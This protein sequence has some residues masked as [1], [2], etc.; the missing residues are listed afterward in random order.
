MT[1]LLGFSGVL[2][3]VP[4]Y[5]QPRVR[6]WREPDYRK[7]LGRSSLAILLATAA[8]SWALLLIR[9]LAPALRDAA[10]H[11]AVI[12]L[13]ML[14]VDA[15]PWNTA[16][17]GARILRWSKAAWALG[18]LVSAASLFLASPFGLLWS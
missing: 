17:A 7:P 3:P 13:V 12:A 8:A 4:H 18:A 14:I 2:L 6:I 5:W 16:W 11:A 10:S 15:Q 9:I 1:L